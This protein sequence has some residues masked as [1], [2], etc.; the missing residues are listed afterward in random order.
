MQT[1]NKDSIQSLLLSDPRAMNKAILKI[2]ERQTEVEQCAGQT[3]EN[4]GIGFNGVDSE[5]MSS[6]AK[7]LAQRGFLTPKQ[8]MIARK[9][10]PKYW[11]QILQLI[12]EKAGA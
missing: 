9:K 7:Q 4:N 5:I 8:T 12:N 2:Y 10:M 11:K 1:W 3:I 6:F